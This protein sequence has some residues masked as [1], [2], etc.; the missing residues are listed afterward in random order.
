MP[1]VFHGESQTVSVQ[2]VAD[3]SG[4]YGSAALTTTSG[5]YVAV[6]GMNFT[7]TQV[8]DGMKLYIDGS[9]G[10]SADVSSAG[11]AIL[12]V[13]DNGTTVQIDASEVQSDPA[14]AGLPRLGVMFAA[15]TVAHCGTTGLGTLS[16]AMLG[17][18]VIGS[19]NAYV[20]FPVNLRARLARD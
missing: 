16:V 20:L 13:N 1:P 18:R 10:I 19:G 9:C 11:S 7:F 6:P 3:I 15:Y 17:R 4:G 14:T 8:V 5:S 12:W 2:S